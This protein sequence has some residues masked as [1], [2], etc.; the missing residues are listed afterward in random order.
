MS[1]LWALFRIPPAAPFRM[2]EEP[3]MRGVLEASP[4][5]R[6]CVKSTRRIHGAAPYPWTCFYGVFFMTLGKGGHKN[7]GVLSSA[8]PAGCSHATAKRSCGGLGALAARRL[9]LAGP[10][11]GRATMRADVGGLD[12]GARRR[13]V[14]DVVMRGQFAGRELLEDFCS[15]FLEGG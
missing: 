11:P 8:T 1:G 3:R 10:F 6:F 5:R 4:L 14:L 15:A 9:I 12:A 2:P 7:A 13:D